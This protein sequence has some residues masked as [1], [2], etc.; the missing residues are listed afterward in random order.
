MSSIEERAKE[1]LKEEIELL[2]DLQD[3]EIRI[4]ETKT[5]IVE[6]MA[7]KLEEKDMDPKKISQTIKKILKDNFIKNISDDTVERACGTGRKEERERYQ[8]LENPQDADPPKEAILTDGS[9]HIDGNPNELSNT[10]ESPPPKPERIEPQKEQGQT[11]KIVMGAPLLG[12]L[13]R[14]MQEKVKDKAAWKK[15]FVLE[16]DVNLK[17]LYIRE[18]DE[19]E[20]VNVQ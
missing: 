6:R 5:E 20:E 18:A 4:G 1:I 17:E 8:S 16:H 2:I 12:G 11:Y 19:G 7:T 10:A 9:S 14:I 13:G 3:K 15:K